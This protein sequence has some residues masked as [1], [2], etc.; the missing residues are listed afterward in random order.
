M[1]KR[2]GVVANLT[3]KGGA[4]IFLLG[5]LTANVPLQAIGFF[6]ASLAVGNA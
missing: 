3:A 4:V 1:C 2:I 5:F 6:S